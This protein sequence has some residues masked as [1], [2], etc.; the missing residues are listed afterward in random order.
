[1]T[2]LERLKEI[3]REIERLDEDRANLQKYWAEEIKA[4][5]DKPKFDMY[6]R[7]GEKALLK[8][9]NKYAPLFVD[10]DDKKD[11]FIEEY[12]YLVKRFENLEENN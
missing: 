3:D 6:S 12:N 7:K 1:M 8:I 10:I 4:E 11:E 2:I 5:M 9:S